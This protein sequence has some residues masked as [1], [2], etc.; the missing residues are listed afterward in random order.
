MSEL[1]ESLEPIALGELNLTVEQFG[2]YT[3]KE[4]TA[5]VDGYIRR[6]EKLEDLFVVYCALPTYQ[7]AFGKHAP[8]YRKLTEHR[9][10]NHPTA[11]INEKDVKE[12][13][14]IL[15]KEGE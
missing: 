9:T 11:K 8:S 1:L 15:S 3:V 2:N 4:I 14:E 12:W 5:L 6:R 13:R 10:H 7:G